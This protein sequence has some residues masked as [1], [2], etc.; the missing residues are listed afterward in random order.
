MSRGPRSGIR[1]Y[2]DGVSLRRSILL[3]VAL[4]LGSAALTSAATPAIGEAAR[5]SDRAQRVSLPDG[6]DVSPEERAVVELLSIVNVERGN[7]GLP[8]LHADDRLMAA[9][10]AH[11]ADMAAMRR[12]QHVGSDGSDAGTRLTREGFAWSSWGENVGAGFLEPRSLFDAW[13]ASPQHRRHLL[14]DF[15]YIGIGVVATPDGVPYWT[16]VVADPAR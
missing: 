12:M 10:A 16:L 13:Y 1:R 6:P 2:R 4:V 8:I 11:S 15:E 14:G 3:A 7:R 9:A 5:V